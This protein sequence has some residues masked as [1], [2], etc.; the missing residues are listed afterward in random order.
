MKAFDTKLSRLK[1]SLSVKTDAEAFQALG[2]TETDLLVRRHS[3]VFPGAALYDWCMKTGRH[4]VAAW[5]NY[6]RH[7]PSPVE[8]KAHAS[9]AAAGSQ[10][11]DHTA[12]SALTAVNALI[13]R[14]RH[15]QA[16]IVLQGL[17][18]NG[19]QIRPNQ[20]DRLA[21]NLAA[22]AALAKTHKGKQDQKVSLS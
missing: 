12:A 21:Q 9:S 3:G 15:G 10:N 8:C 22:V 17:P 1:S 2:L 13:T 4:D 19:V 14:C 7:A 6:G 18:L 16:L 5:V 20:L 11:S